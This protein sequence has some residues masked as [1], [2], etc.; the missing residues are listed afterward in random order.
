MAH[1]LYLDTRL[2]YRLPHRQMPAPFR[3]GAEEENTVRTPP[4]RG[5]DSTTAYTIQEPSTHLGFCIPDG[6]R[7]RAALLL[8]LAWRITAARTS[9]CDWW[10]G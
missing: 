9:G 3:T 6:D 1:S 4:P 5:W 10:T 8:P 2:F 7:A